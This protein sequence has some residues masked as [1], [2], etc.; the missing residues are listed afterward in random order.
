M[1]MKKLSLLR[2]WTKALF[3]LSV[4]PIIFLPAL[5]IIFFFF[6]DMMPM[7]VDILGANE[8]GFIEFI[9]MVIIITGYCLFVYSLYLFRKV[10]ELFSKRQIFSDEVV[11]YFQQIGQLIYYGLLLGA[12]PSNLY[13]ILTRDEHE[14]DMD[15]LVDYIF[16]FSLGLFFTVLSEIFKKAKNLKEENDLTV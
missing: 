3:I 16:V 1:I 12:V 11:K 7:K 10:L 4:L 14:L 8:I 2:D 13:L 5:L 9:V 6:P 15:K